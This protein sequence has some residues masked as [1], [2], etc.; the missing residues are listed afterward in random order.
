VTAVKI[1]GITR[2]EDAV[3]VAQ[4]GADALGFIFYP[5]SP[6]YITPERARQIIEELTLE[7]ANIPEAQRKRIVSPEDP[8]TILSTPGRITTVG[9]FV[10]EEFK[11][12]QE[13]FSFCGLDLIQLHGNESTDYCRQFPAE[14]V[15][16]A[17]AP[18]T[19]DDLRQIRDYPCRAILIDAH[20]PQRH[21][22]TGRTANWELAIRTKTMAPLIL[23]GGLHSGNIR[24]ALEVVR[25]AAVDINSGVETRPGVKDH[26]KVK[27]I[28]DLIYKIFY[29]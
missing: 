2:M 16:K 23:S 27:K 5:Q 3:F 11:T 18:R 8:R 24:E 15:I 6:R 28:L 1:C 26:E 22:G 17:L 9:V 12:V 4:C 7:R 14:R 29:P 20:D 13:I 25:P 21:G 19:D 10:N